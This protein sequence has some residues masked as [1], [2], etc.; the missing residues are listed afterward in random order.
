[1]IGILKMGHARDYIHVMDLVNGHIEVLNYLQNNYAQI[2]NLN[3]GTGLGSSVLELKN[4]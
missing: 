4:F 2:L 1:M 3:I